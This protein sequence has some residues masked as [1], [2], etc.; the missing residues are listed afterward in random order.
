MRFVVVAIIASLLLGGAGPA[1]A[2][3]M[4]RADITD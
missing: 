3:L 2:K 1:Q 4:L